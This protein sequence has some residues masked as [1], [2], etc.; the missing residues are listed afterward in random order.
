ML[1]GTLPAAIAQQQQAGRIA[2]ELVPE[3][4]AHLILA[5][6]D[7]LSLRAF[8]DRRLGKHTLDTMLQQAL[9]RLLV[10]H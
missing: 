6:V 9:S 1:T 4:A 10:S 2:R 5:M 3:Q 8:I 7:G